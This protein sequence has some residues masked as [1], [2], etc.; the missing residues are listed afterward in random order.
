MIDLNLPMNGSLDDPQFRVGPIL[1]KVFTNLLVKVATAPFALLGHLFGGGNEHL[2]IIEFDGGSAELAQPA[3][4][5]LASI[6]KAMK[7]R[8][9]MK[10]DVPM[11][12]SDADARPAGAWPQAKRPDAARAAGAGAALDTPRRGQASIL[13]RPATAGALADPEKHFKLLLEQFQADLG[14]DAALPPSVAGGADR[15]K[16]RRRRPTTRRSP[17]WNAALI[18][19]V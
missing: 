8:P 5:Q 12:S 3:Q 19:H 15:R 10:L 7:E 6:A 18:D 4:D 1:W 14:K 13:I 11:V 2:N 9:Q 16:A 17:T